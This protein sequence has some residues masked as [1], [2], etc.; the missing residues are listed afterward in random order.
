MKDKSQKKKDSEAY[1]RQVLLY[2][3]LTVQP[4]ALVSTE[5]AFQRHFGHVEEL[6]ACILGQL[7]LYSVEHINIHITHI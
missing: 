4:T 3:K 1:A 5:H 2:K 7:F 6:S